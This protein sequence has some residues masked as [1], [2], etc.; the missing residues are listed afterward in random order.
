MWRKNARAVCIPS[1][2]FLLLSGCA[3]SN[4]WG[5]NATLAP[6]WKVI[7][8]ATVVAAT[9][10]NTWIPIVGAAAFGL[11][12]FD[13]RTPD[14]ATNNSPLF[15]SVKR[16]Q[17][18]SDTLESISR[19]NF[20]VSAMLAPSGDGWDGV[21]NKTK[22]L[23][24]AFTTRRINGDMTN[25][26]K[27]ATNRVRPDNSD[28]Y[29][30]PSGHTSNSTV[31]ASLAAQNV[32]YLNISQA[33]KDIWQYSSYTI[34]GLTAWARVEGNRHYPSDVLAGYALGNFLGVFMSQAFINPNLQESVSIE[35][36]IQRSR[37]QSL[38]LNYRW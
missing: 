29:S 34:A 5:Q 9:D 24:I 23:A 26:I 20:F 38:A 12:G 14:W 11:S 10:A 30:F 31:Y 7:Q 36:S 3:S 19:V 25:S 4:P 28:D 21:L 13:N 1:I 6:G 18:A 32:E 35:V 27:F 8:D 37:E 2:T 16:A 22:G 15:R 33:Q 17:N